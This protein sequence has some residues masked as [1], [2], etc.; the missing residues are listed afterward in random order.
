M[1]SHHFDEDKLEWIPVNKK[2]IAEAKKNADVKKAEEKKASLQEGQDKKKAEEQ[3]ALGTP[4]KQASVLQ[5]NQKPNSN[6]AES[7]KP[8]GPKVVKQPT[9]SDQ[10]PPSAQQDA[11]AQKTKEEETRLATLKAHEEERKVKESAA[12]EEEKRKQKNQASK[13]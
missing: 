10:L 8:D 7:A 3:K 11:G 13:R 1:S 2:Y 12:R 9:K 5:Q 6:Q 4:E